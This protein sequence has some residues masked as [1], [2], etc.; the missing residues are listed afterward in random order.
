M[1]P[2]K[3][4]ASEVSNACH[5]RWESLNPETQTIASEVSNACHSQW[6]SLKPDS[7]T[8]AS[9]VSCGYTDYCESRSTHCP[10][11]NS[12]QHCITCGCSGEFTSDGDRICFCDS[13]KTHGCKVRLDSEQSKEPPVRAYARYI[14]PWA[15]SS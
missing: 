2:C 9:E 5:S 1:V 6:E 8:I 13:C 14:H 15:R 10:D 4:I 11:T 12:A 3:A 7:Q